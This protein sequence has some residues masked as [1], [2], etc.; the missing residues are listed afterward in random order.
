MG[1]ILLI[2]LDTFARRRITDM[3]VQ[4]WLGLLS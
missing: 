4:F 3:A 2:I 1:T